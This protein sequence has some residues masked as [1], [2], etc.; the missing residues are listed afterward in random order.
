MRQK[1]F[2]Q[3]KIGSKTY[4]DKVSIEG[5]SDVADFK[6]EIKK[7]FSVLLN[8][9]DTAQ[10]SLYEADG[11]IVIDPETTIG[12]FFVTTGKPYIVKVEENPIQKPTISSTRHQDYKHSKAV[13]SSRSY[14]TSIAVELEKIYLISC[15]MDKRKKITFGHILEEAYHVN[16]EPKPELRNRYMKKLNDFYSA[17]EWNILEELNDSVNPKLHEALA[18][19]LDGKTKEVILPIEVS[20]F[21]QVFKRIAKMT[22]VVSDVNDLIVKNEGSVSGGSPDSEKKV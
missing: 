6:E 15:Y 9:Y 1:Y 11:T 5:C 10:L 2:V 16:P 17:K 3:L 4:K 13:H 18:Y 8:S 14:L 7:K 22:N 12:E 20:H 19:G 21:G